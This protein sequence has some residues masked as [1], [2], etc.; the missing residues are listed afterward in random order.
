MTAVVATDAE[1]AAALAP[2]LVL[3]L[4]LALAPDADPDPAAAGALIGCAHALASGR[5]GPI[6][7]AMTNDERARLRDLRLAGEGRTAVGR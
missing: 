2:T 3:A 5:S 7:S 4:A 6:A 1:A